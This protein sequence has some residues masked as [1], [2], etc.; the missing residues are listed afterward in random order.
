M[1][2]RV[3]LGQW[4]PDDA[5]LEH[6]G[7]TVAKNCVPRVRGKGP[8]PGPVALSDYGSID[9][10]ARGGIGL[11]DPAGVPENFAGDATHLYRIVGGIWVD[12]SIAANYATT[13][14]WEFATFMGNAT[15][16]KPLVLATNYDNE[17]Q[18]FEVGTSALFA[19]LTAN[20]AN[21]AGAVAGAPRARHIGVVGSHVMVG[22]TY[23]AADGLVPTRVWWPT[24]G[25]ASSWPVPGTDG[26]TADQSDYNTL[27][28]DGGH[29]TKVVSGAEVG[30]IFQ[31]RAIW[32]ADYV[33]GEEIFAFSRVEA[34]RGA[35]IPHL[36]VPFGRSVLYLSEDG[37]FV[38]DYTGSRPI[39]KDRIDSWFWNDFSW[40]HRFRTSW[41]VD[42]N[43]TRI[44]IGYTGQGHSGGTPNRIL[45][46]DW[47]LDDFTVIEQEHETLLRVRNPGPDL[48]MDRTPSAIPD[49]LTGDWDTTPTALAVMGGF[50]TSHEL[51]TFS[52][53]ALPATLETGDLELQPGRRSM[54]AAVRP[55]VDGG[56]STVQV[57]RRS[58]RAD[59]IAYGA[60]ASLDSS[61]KA[62]VRADGRYH[63]VRL[64]IGEGWTG[65]AL[66]L[67]LEARPTGGR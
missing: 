48:S 30:A 37:W 39:G 31:E 15:G 49:E 33:G 50:N 29:I 53:S 3:A 1:L 45:I 62:N 7:L 14:K 20:V 8:F 60:A 40:D 65:D 55:V 23:D 10:Y 57:A 43:G 32:R 2:R 41:V 38:F 66:S 9:A 36:A 24:I 42:P 56:T 18:A 61:G 59:A 5:V 6:G 4:R 11:A 21:P 46:W 58:T 54:L 44:A 35:I 16:R 25:N 52:G 19:K 27:F 51:F 28:G 22:Y 34:A 63:R 13:N 67:D 12:V 47:K 26:A 64:S 17:I